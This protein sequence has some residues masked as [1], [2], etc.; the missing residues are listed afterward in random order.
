MAILKA[1]IFVVLFAAGIWQIWLL[2]FK[3]VRG[4]FR[5][6]NSPLNGKT[7]K[8]GRYNA[9]SQMEDTPW[10][11]LPHYAGAVNRFGFAKYKDVVV[12]NNHFYPSVVYMDT[13]LKQYVHDTACGFKGLK[14]VWSGLSKFE[15]LSALI[16]WPLFTA[17]M[18]AVKPLLV[19][20]L[21]FLLYLFFW[22]AASGTRATRR[23][24]E[25][26]R[27]LTKAD[28][29]EIY[30][31]VHQKMAEDARNCNNGWSIGPKGWR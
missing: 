11:D 23:S 20:G 7:M 12:P 5:K 10:D 2:L 19:M 30:D 14:R 17:A 21:I 15:R 26:S 25:R 6:M 3:G 22:Q 29:Q 8:V 16:I 31:D 13:K 1:L 24:A 27:N 28:W 4:L 18:I 9:R